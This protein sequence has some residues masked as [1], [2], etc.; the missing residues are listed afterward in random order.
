L[1]IYVISLKRA[2]E[3]RRFMEEQLRRL[4]LDYTLFDTVE[5]RALDPD[6]VEQY[7]RAQRLQLYG[8]DLSPDWESGLRMFA[9]LPY[10][11][12]PAHS[13]ESTIG[14]RIDIW[15]RPGGRFWRVRTKLLKFAESVAKRRANLAIVAE[16]APTLVPQRRSAG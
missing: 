6:R 11:I 5:G 3:R 14:G 1:Q 13:L 9:V 10:A 8:A 12:N 2:V 15:D 4:G 7:D 16:H